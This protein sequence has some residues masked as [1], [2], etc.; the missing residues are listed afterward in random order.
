[1]SEIVW[2]TTPRGL[3]AAHH[4]GHGPTSD[5]GIYLRTHR[6]AWTFVGGKP[7]ATGVHPVYE[8]WCAAVIEDLHVTVEPAPGARW[9]PLTFAVTV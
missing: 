1:M 8:C 2:K 6:H 7:S 3:V 4:P 5:V 9:S